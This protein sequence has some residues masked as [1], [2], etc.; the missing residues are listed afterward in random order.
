[1]C[2][3]ARPKVGL[4]LC[5]K[6]AQHQE[7]LLIRN[8]PAGQL[9]SHANSRLLLELHVLNVLGLDNIKAFHRWPDNISGCSDL[10]L[11][12]SP[13]ISPLIWLWFLAVW[14]PRGLTYKPHHYRAVTRSEISPFYVRY[15]FLLCSVCQLIQ[16]MNFIIIN[17]NNNKLKTTLM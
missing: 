8:N 9:L 14:R 3:N 17:N 6:A 12:N 1:M 2:D 10:K 5:C 4:K 16:T 11:T 7:E 15:Q 13:F